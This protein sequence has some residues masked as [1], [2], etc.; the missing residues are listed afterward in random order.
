M[1]RQEKSWVL[2]LLA[3]L[4]WAEVSVAA[5]GGRASAV[6]TSG[7]AN[8]GAQ[9]LDAAAVQ[10][11]V[12]YIEWVLDVALTVAQREEAE[13]EIESATSSQDAAQ[14]K[15]IQE[16]I[17]SK[18]DLANHSESD[19][20]NLRS[21]VEDEF[22]KSLKRH[23]RTS[24]LARWI[25]SVSDATRQR[26]VSAKTPLTRQSADAYAELMAFVLSESGKPLSAD[27]AFRDAF[28]K[29][30]ISEYRKLPDDQKEALSDMPH[31]WAA[32]REAWKAMPEDKKQS[33]RKSWATTAAPLEAKDGKV[34]VEG[35]AFRALVRALPNQIATW[36]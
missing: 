30:L 19:L 9:A 21:S 6:A 31:G 16:A 28:T 7:S 17:A 26:L 23:R 13:K 36:L 14:L 11:F 15:L 35:K 25:L 18:R 34:S 27:K 3:V 20:R 24:P 22:L 12:S 8:A 2:P 4:L 33:L 32:L 1:R 29:V 10:D 5:D